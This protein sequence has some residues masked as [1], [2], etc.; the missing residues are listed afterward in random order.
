VRRWVEGRRV[1]RSTNCDPPR[2]VTT[3][4][5]SSRRDLRLVGWAAENFATNLVV[6]GKG[7][8]D[9]ERDER[10]RRRRKKGRMSTLRDLRLGGWAAESFATNLVVGGKGEED[11]EREEGGEEEGKYVYSPWFVPW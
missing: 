7:E 11:E 9:E 8:E 3:V 2:V 10:G 1:G 6:G 4:S 5:M